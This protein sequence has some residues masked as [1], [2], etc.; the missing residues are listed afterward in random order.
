[1]NAAG[2]SPSRGRATL[3]FTL[4]GAAD[5]RVQLDLFD[6]S[7][8]RLRRLVDAMLPGGRYDATW[9]ASDESGRA[10]DPYW[11]LHALLSHGDGWQHFLPLQID[12]RAPFDAA[13]MTGRMEDV[14][15]RVLRRMSI[16][17]SGARLCTP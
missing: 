15:A 12:G 3:V 7:G 2:L 4:A 13:G 10:V 6:L 16:T 1:M 5:R 17:A 8:R 14:L 11:D 9:D